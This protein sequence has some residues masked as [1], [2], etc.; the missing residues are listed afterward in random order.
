MI[1]TFYELALAMV[2][3]MNMPSCCRYASFVMHC[4][5]VSATSSQRGLHIIVSAMLCFLPS[6]K[7]DNETCYVYMLAII[8]SVPFWLIVSKGL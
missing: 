4:L 3:L 7:P 8:S 2:S 5:V 1:H 6:P